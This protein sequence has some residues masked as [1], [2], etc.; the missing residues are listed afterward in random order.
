MNIRYSSGARVGWAND[1]QEEGYQMADLELRVR[2][3]RYKN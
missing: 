1:L 3:H 2:A